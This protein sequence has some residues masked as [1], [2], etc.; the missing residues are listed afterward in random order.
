MHAEIVGAGFVGLT[1]AAR[2]AQH[3]WSVRVHER[4]T[5]IRAF[6]A[7]IWLWENGVGV[8]NAIGAADA[9][10]NGT[11]SIPRMRNM[12]SRDALIHEIP[13]AAMDSPA[14][15]RIFCITR[16]Q[17]LMAIHAAAV[18]AGA[19]FVVG[20]HV[21]RA[22]PEGGIETTDGKRYRGDLVVG[23]DGVNSKVR[24]SLDLL[25]QRRVHIDGATRVLVQHIAG[26]TD[27]PRWKW[28]LEW[29]HGSRRVLYSPCEGD[30]FYICFSAQI[31]D[32]AGSRTPFDAESWAAS[33]PTIADIIRSVGGPTRYD[34]YETIKLH[35]WSR[36]RV[37]LVGDAAHS[38][39]PGL[40][41]GCGMGIANAL[42][43]ANLIGE[44]GPSHETLVDWERRNRPITEHTQLW[45]DI[46]WPKSRW[47]IWGV[48]AFYDF[49][50]WHEWVRNQRTRT[51]RFVPYGAESVPRWNPAGAQVQRTAA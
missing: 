26:R 15:T 30:R 24:D 34:T 42:A 1:I 16:Q 41:Q 7:G 9:A 48:K 3:G 38:M 45:S 47:P 35:Q 37:A 40:G 8:L 5:E 51:A 25:R 12:D 49:P 20:S 44:R 18:R 28:L 4:S 46:S 22:T 32:V 17:L 6:G 14:G 23:A 10:L 11:S 43:L 36:G 21:V 2:L 13:F 39:P 29:W 33:F 27:Q 50:L 19:E 31:R